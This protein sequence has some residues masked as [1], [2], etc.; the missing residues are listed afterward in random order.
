MYANTT[1]LIANL[2]AWEHQPVGNASLPDVILSLVTDLTRRGFWRRQDAELTVAWLQD[3]I[4]VGY[5]FPELNKTAHVEAAVGVVESATRSMPAPFL[6][7]PHVTPKPVRGREDRRE[8][9][10][11]RLCQRK[12]ISNEAE[13]RLGGCRAARCTEWRSSRRDK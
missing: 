13:P 11:D 6:K 12:V 10:C 1:H 9:G 5:Q 2:L 4:S 7:V 3:L 8:V